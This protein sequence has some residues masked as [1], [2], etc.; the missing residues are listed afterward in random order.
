[1]KSNQTI[2]WTKHDLIMLSFLKGISY[3]Q[4][5]EIVEQYIDLNDFCK[6][7]PA[8]VEERNSLGGLFDN[9]WKRIKTLADEQIDLM[10]SNNV[11]LLSI[12]DKDYPEL[13]KSI[14]SPPTFL[15]LKGK[16]VNKKN[17]S[18]VGTRHCTNY[19]KI[20]AENFASA[21][22]IHDLNVV[23]GLAYGIDTIA[24]TYAIKASGTTYAVIASGIDEI[25][26]HYS[27]KLA[28]EIVD[29]DGA[30]ISEYRCGI[31]A[32]PGYFPQRN[33]I[34]SGVSI[35][36]LVVESDIKGGSMIT[37][38][39]AS[40]QGREV[41]AIPGNISSRKSAGCNHLI[42]ENI[43]ALASSPDSILKDIGL[44]KSN[45]IIINKESLTFSSEDE[46]IIFDSI[47]DEPMQIDEIFEKTGMEISNILVK[48]LELEFKS[49]VRQLPGKYYIRNNF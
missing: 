15:Y 14:A 13:L 2:R 39:F 11:E 46:K 5:K 48:L 4:M 47:G 22:A 24:H 6:N 18:I 31:K 32:K 9:P 17:I 26:P 12:W 28:D 7:M 49:Y 29:N 38:R 23:S 34:I 16:I 45:N 37:A 36:T 20:N 43:A 40:D 41:F 3:A 19:G 35:A 44:M 21:F 25:S 1:M 27:Q 30:I 8:S 10:D 42:H 33:R